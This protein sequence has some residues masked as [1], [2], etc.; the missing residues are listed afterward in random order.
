MPPLSTPPAPRG[1]ASQ[2]PPP[3]GYTRASTAQQV[4]AAIAAILAAA[5][6]AI[7]RAVAGAIASVLGGVVLQALVTRRLQVAVTTAITDAR[8][9]VAVQLSQA[10][11]ATRED[12]Q[13][14]LATELGPLARLLPV[15]PFPSLGHLAGDLR[16][17]ELTAAA[18]AM[19]A[20]HRI[21]AQ[22]AHLTGLQRRAAAQ[23]L[24]DDLAA[25]GLRSFTGRDGHHWG[26]STY[27][28]AAAAGAIARAFTA[29]QLAAYQDAGIGLVIV[30]RSSPKPPCARCAPYVGK[31]L[32]LTGQAGM[33]RAFDSAGAMH[34]ARVLTTVADATAHGLLHPQCLDSLAPFT[35]GGD[36]SGE[37]PH[38]PE[39]IAR[40]QARYGAEQ[41]Q[42]RRDR[43]MRDALRQ[44]AV[45]LSPQARTRAARLARHLRNI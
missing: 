20:Y 2:P 8:A 18:A 13:G 12:V 28:E 16:R 35:D 34:S 37:I 7:L 43:A 23:V 6:I 22:T 36:L 11:R 24:L 44:H 5:E 25:T 33:A 31:V 19:G 17:A 21:L 26:L 1:S 39:W 40:Q 45:A 42:R 14:I 4:A 3:S 30:V 9:G 38:G 32:S 41:E 15:V 29:A 10:S 27:A